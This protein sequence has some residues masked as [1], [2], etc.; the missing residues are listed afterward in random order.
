MVDSHSTKLPDYF[1]ME[2]L[3]RNLAALATQ[4]PQLVNRL[5]WPVESG[6][7]SFP[8]NGEAQYL[9]HQSRNPL[10]WPE[11]TSGGAGRQ[12][13]EGRKL[14]VFGVGT[15]E[16]VPILLDTFPNT[17]MTVWDRDPWLVRLFL[18]SRDYADCLKSGRLTLLMGV[19]IVDM[20]G[21]ADTY[22]IVWHPLLKH[23]YHNEAALLRYGMVGEKRLL[24]H[25]RG[26]FVDDV[27]STM[28]PLGY[29]VLYADLDRLSIEEIEHTISRY[30]PSMIMSVNY[31]GGLAEICRKFSLKLMCWEVDP[32]LDA[33]VSLKIPHDGAYVFTYRKS[34]VNVYKAAGFKHV[35]HLPLATNCDRRRPV[36]L[37]DE[38]K[39]LYGSPISFVGNSMAQEAKRCHDLLMELYR[40]YTDSCSD[41]MDER[42][43]L[44]EEILRLQRQDY[45]TFQIR[46]LMEERAG[47][48]LTFVRQQ[49]YRVDPVLCLSEIA[50]SSKRLDTLAALYKKEV[51]VWGD[52]GWKTV[53]RGLITYMG[54]AGHD[55][56]LNRIYSGSLIN[57]DINRIYQSDMVN[58]RVFD[59]MACGGFVLAEF[60]EDLEALFHVGEEIVAYESLDEL[61][62][63]VEYYLARPEEIRQ[64]AHQGMIAVK[65]RHTVRHRV[66]KMLACMGEPDGR[67]GPCYPGMTSR[68]VEHSIG[69]S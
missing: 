43:D 42:Q 7:I 8:E 44:F 21:K 16:V 29:T 3:K 38:E 59:I 56:A 18:M 28:K 68:G 17:E 50:A 34:H 24:V 36:R 10:S 5:C 27:S 4:S 60:S 6:H 47:G 64:I 46:S 1:T 51:R 23:I 15:A 57:L 69:I 65:K 33:N 48:F 22:H 20:A 14:F 35:R 63:K 67:K 61:L 62:E 19:D 41:G 49:G 39:N 54:S 13:F 2:N 53:E 11:V 40:A 32:C 31:Y 66:R 25:A 12:G 55:N 30:R 58:M 45:G 37:T 9:H 52:V 26:L